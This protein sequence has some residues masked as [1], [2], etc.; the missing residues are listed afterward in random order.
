[1]LHVAML[2]VLDALF[3]S[4]PH[5][6]V[7]MLARSAF[8][9]LTN[10]AAADVPPVAN[11]GNDTTITLPTNSIQLNGTKS[12]DPDGSI[13]SYNWF[14]SA[15]A[16]GVTIVNANTATPTIV[17]LPSAGTYIFTLTVIDNSGLTGSAS[18]TVTL[19]PGSGTGNPGGGSS[20]LVA[21]AGSDTSV[22]LP[23]GS[24][25]LDGSR[26]TDVGGTITTYSWAQLSGPGTAVLTS[27]GSAVCPVSGLVT[28]QYVFQLT[29]TDDKGNTAKDTV[30]VSAVFT[31]RSADNNNLDIFP[32]PAQDVVNMKITSGNNGP[33][34]IN[35]VSSSG[36]LVQSIQSDKK[37][38]SESRTLN[39][40][41]LS[42]GVYVVQVLIG[43]GQTRIVKKLV[44]Q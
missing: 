9:M 17:G 10:A 39:V 13:V 42:R 2:T 43:D 6:T 36:T 41:S 19:N 31:D 28:G 29:V 22:A 4:M 7:E 21:D 16:S 33:M 26:S 14:M 44:K 27:A 5:Y 25:V 38:T 18:V 1:M 20:S 8:S 23:A 3:D 24:L 35:I 30:I 37:L 11:A 12:Y 34:Q 32:N 40:G 15:G